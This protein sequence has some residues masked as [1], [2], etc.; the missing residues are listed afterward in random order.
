MKKKF[1]GLPASIG[2]R[3][4]YFGMQTCYRSAN[5][6]GVQVR[7]R[8]SLTQMEIRQAVITTFEK[9]VLTES[10]VLLFG[11]KRHENNRR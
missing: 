5:P 8:V 3:T 6:L 10:R 11:I 1:F 4:K 9:Y 7:Q 2:I